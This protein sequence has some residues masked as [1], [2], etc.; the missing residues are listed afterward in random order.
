[1]FLN[2]NNEILFFH[3]PCKFHFAYNNSEFHE[4]VDLNLMNFDEAP[5]HLAVSIVELGTEV[6]ISRAVYFD[7][8]EAIPK[9]PFL[10]L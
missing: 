7:D 3:S 5:L 4:G 9:D 10:L 2:S 8:W 1:M 6:E